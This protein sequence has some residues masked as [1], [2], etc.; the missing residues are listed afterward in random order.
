MKLALLASLFVSLLCHHVAIAHFEPVLKV[1]WTSTVTNVGPDGRFVT[2]TSSSSDDSDFDFQSFNDLIFGNQGFPNLRGGAFQ[3]GFGIS[4]MINSMLSDMMGMLNFNPPAK[5][6]GCRRRRAAA[7]CLTDSKTLCSGVEQELIPMGLCLVSK[8]PQ[9]SEPC[10][11]Y[12]QSTVLWDCDQDVAQ[13]CSVVRP[14]RGRLFE[15]LSAHQNVLSATCKSS[16]FPEEAP[17]EVLADEMPL[18]PL[19][20]TPTQTEE[21]A[22]EQREEPVLQ[23]ELSLAPAVV[24]PPLDLQPEFSTP[25]SSAVAV[26]ASSS[27]AAN[28]PLEAGAVQDVQEAVAEP[29][30]HKGKHHHQHHKKDK[31]EKREKEREKKEKREK[32]NDEAAHHEQ[33]P[34]AL[35]AESHHGYGHKHKVKFAIIFSCIGIAVFVVAAA[36]F[37]KRRR[38]R[39]RA[40]ASRYIAHGEL[41][42][43]LHAATDYEHV[44]RPM[45]A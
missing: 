28:V 21:Q 41:Y 31:K 40:A 7:A 24:S 27:A 15:C 34:N 43:P 36:I 16:L 37:V 14:G 29:A 19:L 42:Q 35:A 44:T 20:D 17:K 13:F 18:T 39:A 5:H 23:Q 2:Q 22:E 8:R 32:Q 30:A 33:H 3:P 25:D 45:A 10:A 38:A 1:S 9:L 6:H 4:G 12:L 26:A 11:R